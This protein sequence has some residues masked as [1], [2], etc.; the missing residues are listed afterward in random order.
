MTAMI[1]KLAAWSMSAYEANAR[2]GD[3]PSASSG[4]A[5]SEYKVYSFNMYVIL[6]PI[7]NRHGNVS[8]ADQQDLTDGRQ[9]LGKAVAAKSRVNISGF[10]G[11]ISV[12]VC[13]WASCNMTW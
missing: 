12:T 13:R 1:R 3:S 11:S 7:R 8:Y 6:V 4:V 2:Q 5:A 10:R 9:A